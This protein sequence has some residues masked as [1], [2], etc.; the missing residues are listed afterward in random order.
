MAAAIQSSIG[1][2]AAGSS[3]ATAQAIGMGAAVPPIGIV[4]GGVILS[5]SMFFAVR[6]I[7]KYI[8]LRRERREV[9]LVIVTLHPFDIY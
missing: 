5:V 8:R 1:S 7:R 9:R 6:I 2:V 3:F 4:L